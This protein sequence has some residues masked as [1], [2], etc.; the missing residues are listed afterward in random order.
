MPFEDRDISHISGNASDDLKRVLGDLPEL[1]GNRLTDVPRPN[2]GE[3]IIKRMVV[4]KISMN[5]KADEPMK[6]EG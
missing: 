6:L 3:D 4:T 5:K 1:F 2:F